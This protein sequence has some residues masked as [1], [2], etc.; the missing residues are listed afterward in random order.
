MG[1]YARVVSSLLGCSQTVP[2]RSSRSKCYKRERVIRSFL[3][4][5]TKMITAI[6]PRHF[7]ELKLASDAIVLDVRD[8]REQYE[9][10][11]IPGNI[12]MDQ[13]SAGFADQL[14]RLD[15]DKR[16]LV[17]CRTGIRSMEVCQMMD[18]M[19]F[20]EVYSLDGGI[21]SWKETFQS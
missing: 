14:D 6:K 9:E 2:H 10:G 4:S 12:R 1:R 21:V 11:Q 19:G 16:Y 7:R 20:G 17:Y 13:A 8:A 18:S 3:P 15:R 5:K